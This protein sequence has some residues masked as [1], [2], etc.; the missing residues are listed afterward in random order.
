MRIV[1][2]FGI[3]AAIVTL[4]LTGLAASQGFTAY[5]SVK[6]LLDSLGDKL[7]PAIRNPSETKWNAWSR[8]E[9]Q[10]IRARLDQGDLDSM[11]NL[12][13]FGTSFTQQPR[14]RI[15][16]IA[17]ASRGGVLQARV[18]DLLKGLQTPGENERLLFLRSL[19]LRRKPEPD[20]TEGSRQTGVFVLDNLKRVLEELRKYAQRTEEAK[21]PNDATAEFIERSRLFRDRG[22]SLDTSIF[23]NFGVEEAL[24][25][26][27][28]RGV[29][30]EGRVARVAVIGPGLDFIDW[31]SGFD[32]YP[33]QT[34]QPFALYNALERTGLA[35][36]GKLSGT[37]KVTVFDISSRVLNH[38]RRARERAKQGESYV[39]QL[40][41]N[42]SRHWTPG[43]ISY[44]REF[45][46][47]IGVAASPI[48]PPE[49][50][51]VTE[52]RAVRIRPEVVLACEPVDLDIVTSHS[53]LAAADR[54]DLVV[55]TN[56]FL[57]YDTAEQTFALHN[58]ASM[59]KPGGLLLSNTELPE[60]AAI[61][62]RV[63]G[64]TNARY[65]EAPG[66][67]DQVVWYQTH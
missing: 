64:A 58:V 22:V 25:D 45:G 49:A 4:A 61:P 50:L 65:A 27:K 20:T 23:P 36:A 14:I 35:P 47:R 56:I 46:D 17:Q 66:A 53:D 62:V 6:P 44:W 51:Q 37:L 5:S 24:R 34:L 18:N 52:T 11:V 29:L 2:V 8:Q 57:Y 7:P 19:A 48:Q 41:R 33:Q 30:R 12:L 40:P 59:L 9:D 15:E 60:S 1:R 43:V 63:A 38:L 55:G 10:S 3:V 28:N 32:Y 31:D 54:F 13:L 26:L 21:R 16:D 42:P 39:V 67:G